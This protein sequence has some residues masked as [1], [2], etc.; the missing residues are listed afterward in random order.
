MVMATKRI[1]KRSDQWKVWVISTAKLLGYK[2][3]PVDPSGMP[4]LFMC[5]FPEFFAVSP[6][7]GGFRTFDLPLAWTLGD[8]ERDLATTFN[9]VYDGQVLNGKEKE[10]GTD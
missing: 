6:P 1:S 3:D 8:L 10:T 2:V 9:V 5:R 4:E 7:Y